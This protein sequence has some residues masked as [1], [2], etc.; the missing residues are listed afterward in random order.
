LRRILYILAASALIAVVIPAS[1]L[2]HGR[3]HHR[4]HHHHFRVHHRNFG[5]QNAP[6]T[7]NDADNAGT[8]VSFTNDVLTIQ[9]NNASGG[10]TTVS[11]LV[12]RDTEIECDNV[13]N[14]DNDNDNDDIAFRK[15]DHGPGGGDN[16]DNGNNG[17]HGDRGDNRGDDNDNDNDND[18]NDMENCGTSNLTMGTVVHEA[19]LQIDSLGATWD[20]VELV[21]S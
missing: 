6:M 1:A 3:S 4:R 15:D 2:A 9:L 13:N 5:H 16:G 11:G 8:V 10:S 21:L 7:T 17:D 12:T 19:R 14:N 18:D 20:K